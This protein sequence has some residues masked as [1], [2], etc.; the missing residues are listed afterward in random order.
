M[1]RKK[2]KN[3]RWVTIALLM[4]VLLVLAGS[5]Y[6]YYR[7]DRSLSKMTAT[8]EE[9]E[10]NATTDPA[11]MGKAERL[12]PFTV[13]IM[14]VDTRPELGYANTDVMMLAAFNPDEKSIQLLSIPRDTRVMIPDYGYAKINA[15][16]A[17]GDNRK[18]R[19]EKKGEPITMTG[20]KLAKQTVTGLFGVPIDHYVLLDFE[21]F[22]KIVDALGGIDIDVERRLVYHDP[23]DGTVIDLQPGLQHLDGEQ[24]LGYVRHRHDDR[25]TK[26]YSSDFDRN[27]RQ[28]I[29]IQAVADKVKSFQG[30]THIF[31]LLDI[32]GD[33]VKS[34]FTKN[35]IKS[36][37]S[38]YLG[39]G[40]QAITT[41]EAHPYWD[42]IG[43]T[44][45]PKEDLE[46]IRKTLWQ[47]LQISEEQGLALI[48]PKNDEPLKTSSASGL[49][50]PG[51]SSSNRTNGSTKTTHKPSP[52]TPPASSKTQTDVAP[53]ST[54]PD[55]STPNNGTHVPDQSDQS[56]Q[57]EA[58]APE[59]SKSPGDTTPA[60]PPSSTGDATRSSEPSP[61]LT[62]PP[63]SGKSAEDGSALPDPLQQLPN[64]SKP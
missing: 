45:F 42:G 31:E 43:Y 37:A 33:H 21:A 57:N 24:A 7:I 6:A 46:R 29:V 41:I 39:V 10:Q 48:N 52:S 26:Y 49:A 13:L 18:N 1:D 53:E 16:Y 50:Q 58:Q 61:S 27:R 40:S 54:K 15:A 14:G 22:K 23:T 8:K 64:S 3:K 25:G 60:T 59:S 32:V 30:V 47:S 55:A 35:E 12:E 36:L 11:Q 44:L 20:P 9:V 19:A 17:I 5:I 28:Q 4:F 63:S 2:K 62:P 56:D 34:D 38:V 51:K